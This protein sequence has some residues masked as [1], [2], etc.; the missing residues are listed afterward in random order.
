MKNTGDTRADIL[1]QRN[2]LLH[3]TLK[4]DKCGYVFDDRPRGI[5]D[6][7]EKARE[8]GWI[9]NEPR[10]LHLCQVCRKDVD[11]IV[12]DAI[13]E[14]RRKIINTWPRFMLYA[15]VFPET[16]SLEFKEYMDVPDEKEA[17][18]LGVVFYNKKGYNL[19]TDFMVDEQDDA[20]EEL[21]RRA[22]KY[23]DERTKK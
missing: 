20:Q 1:M 3:S 23:A 6:I 16:S 14:E 12:N 21:I 7:L 19:N 8:Q 18:D 10:G 9:A 11:N 22:M 15:K 17:K 13:Q 4:C 5:G 2:E